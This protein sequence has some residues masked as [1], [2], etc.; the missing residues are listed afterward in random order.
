[1]EDINKSVYLFKNFM[2]QNETAPY[3]ERIK[4]KYALVGDIEDF[5]TRT[6]DISQDPIVEK[7]KQFI[8][9]ELPVKLNCS[10]A[11][12]QIWPEGSKSELHIH[13]DHNRENGDFNSLIY[14]ND[15]FD[16][17]EFITEFS[18]YKPEVG[19]LTFFNGKQNYHGV[20]EVKRAHRFTLI[21]WWQNTIILES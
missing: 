12:I 19:T 18:M 16:D 8:E 2:H 20:T 7:V 14:L 3:I 13:D 10:Q 5:D 17:G 9:S 11:Q 1:M 4:N 21:F 15:D 6:I